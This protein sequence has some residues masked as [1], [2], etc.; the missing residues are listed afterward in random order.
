MMTTESFIVS[1]LFL[2]RTRWNSTATLEPY[3]LTSMTQGFI[4]RFEHA[5][6]SQS[7]MAVIEWLLVVLNAINKIGGFHL[8]SF[9][10][11]D[12][13]RPHIA[14]AIADQL[15]VDRFTATHLNAPI[16]DFYFFVGFQIVPNQHLF[17]STEQR[18]PNFDGRK[19]VH[20]DVRDQ[21]IRIIERD[22][23]DIGVSIQMVGSS[24]DHCLWFGQ[25]QMIDDRKI[26]RGQVPDDV[27]VVLKQ[28]KVHSG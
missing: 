25:N 3:D 27:H 26:V 8:Q 7:G 5:D 1:D 13:R 14:G 21:I 19:P 11:L 22:K 28:S 18:G 23:S 6:N 4:R 24:G 16:V 15:L 12:I 10:L 9:D 20:I 17:L 2:L